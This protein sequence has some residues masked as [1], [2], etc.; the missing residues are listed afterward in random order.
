MGTVSETV[1]VDASPEEVFAFLDDPE[2]HMTVTPSISEIDDVQRLENGG[3]RLSYTFRMAG[4]PLDGEL[5]QTVHEEGEQMAFD[6]RGHLSGEIVL[7]MTAVDGGTELTYSATYEIPGQVIASV[8]EPFARRYNE[9][10]LRTTL[11]NVQTHFELEASG[12][13]P[14]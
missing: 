5:V 14:E 1:H 6:M 7:T 4:I 2:N 13:A 8:A 10:E 9:R 12:G 11:E 3:K